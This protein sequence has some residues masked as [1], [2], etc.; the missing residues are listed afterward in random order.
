VDFLSIENLSKS[1]DGVTALRQVGLEVKSGKIHALIGPNGAGKTTL[2]NILSGILKPTQ[3]RIRFKG[4]QI[5]ALRPDRITSLGIGRTFQNIR[6]FKS[7]TVLENVMVGR[8]CRT[9]TGLART[10]FSLPFKKLE[11]E[12][13]IRDMANELLRFVSL[14]DKKENKAASLPYGSQRR[15]EIAR[16]LAAEPLLL[17]LDEPTAGMDTQETEDLAALITKI[18][19]QGVTI[20]LIEH[21]MH[22][23]MGISDVVTVLNFGRKI[24][25]GHPREIQSSPEVI[26]AYLGAQE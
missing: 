26:E 4:Q 15:L 2:F 17:L 14:F 16:A 13:N 8:H 11:E 7:L 6:L 12:I 22:L 20:L 1:F 10:F 5:D 18:R 19:D 23:V 24:A 25:E 21:D 3:G 9:R